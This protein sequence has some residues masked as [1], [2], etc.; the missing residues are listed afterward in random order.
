MPVADFYIDSS[1][2]LPSSYRWDDGNVPL[3]NLRVYNPSDTQVI[4]TCPVTRFYFQNLSTGADYYLWD[5]GDP[6]NYQSPTPLVSSLTATFHDYWFPGDYTVSLSAVHIGSSSIDILTKSQY[7]RMT[8]VTQP[9]ANLTILPPNSGFSPFTATFQFSG[10]RSGAFP[11]QSLLLDFGDGSPI[12]SINRQLSSSLFE[13]KSRFP[14]DLKDPRNFEVSHTYQIQ[15]LFD[16]G[17]FYPTLSVI[18]MGTNNKSLISNIVGPIKLPPI[19]DKEYSVIKTQKKGNLTY[20]TLVDNNNKAL[21]NAI[22][23]RPGIIPSPQIIQ[24]S[25]NN[26]LSPSTTVA[27]S[28]NSGYDM[29]WL[30][31]IYGELDSSTINFLNY[32]SHLN[33]QEI[34]A[35]DY[36][37]R[38]LKAINIWSKIAALY[39]FVG[40]TAESHS[41]NLINPLQFQI[42]WNGTVTHDAN[43]IKGDGAT[44]YG[45]TG[46]NATL[47]SPTS[48]HLSVYVSSDDI[49]VTNPRYEIGANSGTI[50][51]LDGIVARYPAVGGDSRYFANDSG[52]S[53]NVNF[54]KGLIVGVKNG[55]T[56]IITNQNKE[57]NSYGPVA[58]SSQSNANYLLLARSLGTGVDRYSSNRICFASI[59]NY[60]TQNETNTLIDIVQRYQTLLGRA[61]TP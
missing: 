8:Q 51:T 32:V 42:T 5:F 16:S 19:N 18:E 37:V 9:S 7:V 22:D 52:S 54:T 41:Y 58:G 59:G 55:T 13:N 33:A 21:F 29:D 40:G 30:K 36:L 17:T 23:N 44:G 2:S 20:I 15:S 61:I 24:R 39:P 1:V 25:T 4:G 38:E 6:F 28:G 26:P 46:L 47:L 34:F 14:N 48:R 27:T 3:N 57:T 50:H 11:I 31:V 56:A 10:S 60:L 35:I 45:N 43:G 12:V 49:S 53:A